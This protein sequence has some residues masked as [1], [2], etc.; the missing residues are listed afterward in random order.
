MF[1][2][3][4]LVIATKYEK[5]KV[6]AS[7]LEDALGVV[8]FIQDGFDTDTLGAFTGE[9]ERKLDPISTARKKCLRAMEVIVI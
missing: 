1:K 7:L 8:C 9:I 5:E 4:S 2:G 3:R 6:I